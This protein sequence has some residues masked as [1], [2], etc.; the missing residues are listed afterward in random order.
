MTDIEFQMA[1][2]AVLVTVAK[3][4]AVFCICLTAALFIGAVIEKGTESEDPWL[5]P[6]PRE[7]DVPR[8]SDVGRNQ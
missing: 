7:A 4:A 1:L 2:E 5:D 8:Y 3:F 6:E